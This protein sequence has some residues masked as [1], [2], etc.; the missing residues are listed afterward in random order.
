MFRALGRGPQAVTALAATLVFSCPAVA[1]PEL[2][3][4]RVE[5]NPFSPDGL[6]PADRDTTW[7]H[8]AVSEEADSVVVYLAGG[9]IVPF[10]H[11]A[12]APAPPVDYAEPWDGR[13]GQGELVAD[14]LYWA[15][16]RLFEG[17]AQVDE[18]RLGVEADT[19]APDLSLVAPYG[20]SPFS[21][22][23]DGFADL[24]R[25]GIKVE[26]TRPNDDLTRGE[27]V[28]RS[29]APVAPL[30]FADG[31]RERFG[32]VP[33]D[34][35][36]WDGESESPPLAEGLYRWSVVSIDLAEN[37][38]QEQ[39][40]VTVDLRAPTLTTDPE[41]PQGLRFAN[42]DTSFE[43]SGSAE[44]TISWVSRV[45]LSPDQG[46]SWIEIYAGSAERV[47]W[48]HTLPFEPWHGEGAYRYRV[49]A[50]DGQAHAN[51]PGGAPPEVELRVVFDA[52][53]PLHLETSALATRL[54]DGD[55]L[56]LHSIW[57][58]DSL[59]LEV[60]LSGID[61]DYPPGSAEIEELGG[62]EYSIRHVLP[63][64]SG[65]EQQPPRAVAI[66]ARDRANPPVVAP[67]AVWLALDNS[68]PVVRGVELGGA[69]VVAN[70][71]S[72]RLEVQADSAGYALAVDFSA[73]D[74]QFSAGE[75]HVTDLGA[76][77]YRVEHQISIANQAPDRDGVELPVVVR[78]AAG[79]EALAWSPPIDLVNGSNA[80][81]VSA[82]LLPSVA[83]TR[84]G[85]VRI[86]LSVLA[87]ESR[88]RVR[89]EAAEGGDPV[90][91]L[92]D[93]S[94]AAGEHELSWDGRDDAGG[95]AADGDYSV[96]VEAEL[97]DSLT[98]LALGLRVDTVAPRLGELALEPASGVL[99]PDGD[100]LR[101]TLR[102]AVRVIGGD[103]EPVRTI[104]ELLPPDGAPPLRLALAE[105]GG[106][107]FGGSGEARWSWGGA[108]ATVDGPY[109]L[110]VTTL[111]DVLDVAGEPLHVDSLSA[112]IE[113]D[114]N[115]PA[116]DFAL[117]DS[118]GYAALPLLLEGDALDPAGV[119]GVELSTNGGASWS[120]AQWS[121]S[122]RVGADSLGWRF[123]LAAHA[124]RILARGVDSFG[125]LSGSDGP[126]PAASLRLSFDAEAPRIWSVAAQRGRFEAGDTLRVLALV[127]DPRA[128]VTA[129]FARLDSAFD[130]ARVTL[131]QAPGDT[132][133][134]FEY[135][136]SDEN[137]R[138]P[139]RY[140]VIVRAD[141]GL[142]PAAVDSTLELRLVDEGPGRVR[143]PARWDRGDA[144]EVTLDAPATLRFEIFDLAANLIWSWRSAAPASSHSIAWERRNERGSKVASGAYLCRIAMRDPATGKRHEWVRPTV[145]VRR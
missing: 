108:G 121:D 106:S 139:G 84:L 27:I 8:F 77:A 131:G 44:D 1:A 74:S 9:G 57:S 59:A 31:S 113:V 76:G 90:R 133:F 72:L 127:D 33:R 82:R 130:P 39:G 7:I 64:E 69:T 95:R 144:A 138:R 28:D 89:V 105:G 93:T 45:E 10:R 85:T 24:F 80:S 75:E 136:V 135:V 107:E 102:V 96:A 100:L 26:N 34:S 116:I 21:P 123:V 58:E 40:T 143:V 101:D 114:L 11:A 120:A 104:A 38:D 22:D 79:N 60:D 98:R 132:A 25:F 14:G 78:D 68:A 42:A 30:R 3:G 2:F 16:L 18:R 115:G 52:T 92:A 63:P 41:F 71:D 35:L 43:L 65:I 53:P 110:R 145:V 55:T 103:P 97:G 47:D 111:D 141:D 37:R 99:T 54:K 109:R 61:P 20:I 62:G 125:H 19:R 119:R 56:A 117:G 23:D 67:E 6:P 87:A 118:A 128:A 88:V 50:T 73:L 142:H 48:S 140:P 83:D 124:S 91:A 126:Q 70:G 49:R 66:T 36:S 5:P 46:T 51:R 29:G 81:L 94:L 134:H 15:Q 122:A 12:H 17:G 32:E 137:Q 86:E 13:D 112:E 129:D 4:A